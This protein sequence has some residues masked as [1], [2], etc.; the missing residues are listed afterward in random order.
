MKYERTNSELQLTRDVS[1]IAAFLVLTVRETVSILNMLHSPDGV[2]KPF[3]PLIIEVDGVA[4]SLPYSFNAGTYVIQLLGEPAEGFDIYLSGNN[5]YAIESL[6][7]FASDPYQGRRSG[8]VNAVAGNNTITFRRLPDTNYVVTSEGY[9][10]VAGHE[11]E[12]AVVV[13][14]YSSRTITSVVVECDD[15][16]QLFYRIQ[17]YE[18]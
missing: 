14:D 11:G 5:C 12:R 16:C 17:R 9:L 7:L 8:V 13:P 1:D 18:N 10:T 15:D 6:E 3:H 4:A 2:L